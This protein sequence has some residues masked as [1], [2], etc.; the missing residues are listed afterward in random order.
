MEI[1]A[2]EIDQASAA[3][4][5]DLKNRDMLTVTLVVWGGEFGRTLCGRTSMGQ[6]NGR[7][8]RPTDVHQQ[9]VDKILA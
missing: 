7:A 1:C 4:I 6:G 9:V 8:F 2:L 3:L 5:Q